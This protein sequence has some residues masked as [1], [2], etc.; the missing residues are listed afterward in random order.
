MDDADIR[1]SGGQA[2]ENQRRAVARTIVDEDDFGGLVELAE[3][4]L[5]GFIERFEALCLVEDRYDDR[6]IHCPYLRRRA[7][8][9]RGLLIPHRRAGGSVLCARRGEILPRF[10]ERHRLMLAG[11]GSKHIG[12]EYPIWTRQASTESTATEHGRQPMNGRGRKVTSQ[13]TPVIS[14]EPRLARDTPEAPCSPFMIS[15]NATS[16]GAIFATPR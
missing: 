7:E 6:E 14:R 1:I 2:V 15:R 11:T 4:V 10:S 3:N 9:W 12:G 16:A 13:G 5:E 8:R